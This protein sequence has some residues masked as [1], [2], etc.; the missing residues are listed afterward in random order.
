M[1]SCGAED[2]GDASY[3]IAKHAD[4]GRAIAVLDISTMPRY[5]SFE[6]WVNS[7]PLEVIEQIIEHGYDDWGGKPSSADL[8]KI[9]LAFKDSIWSF[10]RN[11]SNRA[12]TD[13]LFVDNGYFASTEAEL[14]DIVVGCAIDLAASSRVEVRS[15]LFP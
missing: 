1:R 4:A 14:I 8:R 6:D 10:I 3:T 15:D 7:W 12:A 9:Y 5:L 11:K 2:S 13:Y